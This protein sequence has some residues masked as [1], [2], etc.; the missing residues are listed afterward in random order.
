MNIS[1]FLFIERSKR[2]RRCL[3]ASLAGYGARFETPENREYKREIGR[4][5][6]SLRL[7][8]NR[9]K[10]KRKKQQ[11]PFEEYLKSIFDFV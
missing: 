1:I 10:K 6:V 8:I 4:K 7:R 5:C 11:V 9:L 2:L 3:F